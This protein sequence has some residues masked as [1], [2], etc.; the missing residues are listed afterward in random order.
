M[1]IKEKYICPAYI[2]K[3]NSNCEKQDDSINDS[4]QRK[5]RMVLSRSKE[6]IYIIK[7][8]NMKHHGDFYCLNCLHSFRTENNLKSHEKVCEKK[9][10]CGIVMLPEQ[11]KIL[12][13]NQNMKSDKML[14][15]IYAD[16]ESLIK[17]DRWMCK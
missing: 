14:Y 5:R 7:R 15:I 6:T 9:D 17:K 3:T 13:F 11:D 1:H 16:M 12:E 4:K 2:S 8:N 10:F